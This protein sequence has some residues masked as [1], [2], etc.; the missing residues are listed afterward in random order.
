MS[1]FVKNFLQEMKENTP[2]YIAAAV[3]DVKSGVLYG[4]DTSVDSFDPAIASVFNLE[5]AKSKLSAIKALGLKSKLENIMINLSDQIHIIDM[6][7]NGEYFIYLAVDSSKANL[8]MT[9]AML[10]KYK[11]ALKDNL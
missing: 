4:S 2:G 5:V 3:S 10:N 8:G 1:D 11:K 9:V 6:C 7:E